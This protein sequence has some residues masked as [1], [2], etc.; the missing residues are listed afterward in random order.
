MHVRPKRFETTARL[1]GLGATRVACEDFAPGRAVVAELLCST[2]E[3]IF[4]PE[5]VQTVEPVVSANGKKRGAEGYDQP[6]AVNTAD[7][8]IL[9]D[10]F[11]SLRL[12]F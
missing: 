10:A 11:V 2:I 12:F 3:V 6:S 5:P 9:E 7:K 1:G 4:D 8:K